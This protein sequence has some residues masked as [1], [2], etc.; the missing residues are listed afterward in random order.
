MILSQWSK[1]TAGDEIVERHRYIYMEVN[2]I[3]FWWH[4]IIKVCYLISIPSMYN[5]GVLPYGCWVEGVT[6]YLFLCWLVRVWLPWLLTLTNRTWHAW[7]VCQRLLNMS[8]GKPSSFILHPSVDQNRLIQLHSFFSL[9]VLF[10]DD[11][12]SIDCG[13]PP[14][15]Q[16]YFI[17]LWDNVWVFRQMFC[18]EDVMGMVDKSLCSMLLIRA[19]FSYQAAS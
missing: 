11:N 1:R 15:K 18:L 10:I 8:L 14:R 13:W 7:Q 12:T 16:G 6:T 5:K 9:W 4:F 3:D 19:V 17:V 2:C